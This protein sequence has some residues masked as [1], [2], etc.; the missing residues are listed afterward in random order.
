VGFTHPTW[1]FLLGYARETR[2]GNW[3]GGA[4]EAEALLDPP[5]RF[6]VWPGKTARPTRDGGLDLAAHFEAENS[7]SNSGGARQLPR[8]QVLAGRKRSLL[9]RFAGW[10]QL[11]LV[12]RTFDG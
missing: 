7:S 9:L 4:F 2:E 10:F 6:F 3:P 12:G 1:K 11:S 5:G 8:C